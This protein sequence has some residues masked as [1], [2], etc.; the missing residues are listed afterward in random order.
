MRAGF[1]MTGSAIPASLISAYKA[2]DYRVLEPVAFTMKIGRRSH[3]LEDLYRRT[4]ARTATVITAWNPRSEKKTDAENAAAQASLIA[5]LEAAGLAHLP[6][7]G[8]DPKGEWKGEV[9]LLV[10]DATKEAVEALGRNYGQ[11]CI[12]WVEADA[13]PVLLFLR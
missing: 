2:T 7:L 6:A 1:V 13:V 5:D 12:V 10:L 8:A 3:E 4:G 9:S 11:N